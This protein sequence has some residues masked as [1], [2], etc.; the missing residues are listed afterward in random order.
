MKIITL[1]RNPEIYTCYAYLLL[2]D[3]KTLQDVNGLVDV[4][5]DGYILNEIQQ[6]YTGVGKKPIEKVVLTHGHC[7]HCGGLKDIVAEFT[8]EVLSFSRIEN[9]ETL[10]IK[11][12]DRVL[13]ADGEFEVIHTPGHSNDS[14]CLYCA[15][16]K[17]LFS[18]DT[19]L[20]ITMPEY[21]Y[22]WEFITALEKLAAK[23]IKII[24]SGHDGV[25]CNDV[26][27]MIRIT[28]D[29]VLKCYNG[30]AV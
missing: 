14:I 4:G 30:G 6:I 13:L 7:D 16:E 21:G 22:G 29:N 23:D 10:I 18:G 20:R 19:P 27:T 17:V 5:S 12:G 8:P 3:F 9:C 28:L 11:N 24:Y 2:G 15:K 25:I 1:K 26:R